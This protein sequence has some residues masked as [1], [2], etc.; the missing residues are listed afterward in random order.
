[1][2]CRGPHEKPE[3]ESQTDGSAAGPTRL[4]PAPYYDSEGR[5][6]HLCWC[7]RWG[8]HGFNYDPRHGRLGT[9]FCGEHKPSKCDGGEQA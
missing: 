4:H 2:P 6:I 9:W 1:M 5:F 8:M 3:R 7:G